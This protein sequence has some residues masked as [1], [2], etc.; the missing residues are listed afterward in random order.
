M[1]VTPRRAVAGDG[2]DYGSCAERKMR[3]V[4]REMVREAYWEDDVNCAATM[5]RILERAHGVRIV[6]QVVAAATGMH[7]AGC[8][9]A[10]CGLVEGGLMFLGIWGWE[11][12]LGAQWI[13]A[14]CRDYAREFERCFGSL[15]CREL[16]PQGF[17]PD[18][19][20]HACEGLTCDAGMWAVRWTRRLHARHDEFVGEG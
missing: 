4:V 18:Q 16:R 2:P 3:D 9:G 6:P 13:E 20:P 7:G 10:Q 5:L 14:A 15:L 1:A 11:R 17:A 8:Y 19:P 12:G